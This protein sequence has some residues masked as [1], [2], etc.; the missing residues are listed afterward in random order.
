MAECLLIDRNE[1]ERARFREQLASLGL[2]IVER[3]D[4]LQGLD[5][6]NDNQPDVVLMALQGASLKT[7]DFIGRMHRNRAG[8]RPVVIAYGPQSHASW[9]G[10]T[11]L[12]GAA[13]VLLLPVDSDIIS[14][15]LRQA[16]IL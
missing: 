4:A 1:T 16:G 5:Y 11:I 14:F 12:D 10:Q 13:E 9:I 8:R 6:C 2:Q 3:D 7:A 15:K